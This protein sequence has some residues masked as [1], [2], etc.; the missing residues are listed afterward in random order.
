[1]ALM[2]ES[3][4]K[5]RSTQARA[6]LKTAWASMQ[7]AGGLIPS[8]KLYDLTKAV[9]LTKTTGRA[10]DKHVPFL[11]QDCNFVLESFGLSPFH[12]AAGVYLRYETVVRARPRCPIPFLFAPISPLPRPR[13]RSGTSQ[14]CWVTGGT[15]AMC[16]SC[17]P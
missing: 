16:C 4:F 5:L 3:E 15:T 7:D 6:E 9:K 12:I 1:M 11:Q 13:R 17:G 14:S 10:N 2:S 8:K